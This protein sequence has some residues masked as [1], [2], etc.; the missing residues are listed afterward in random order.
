MFCRSHPLMSHNWMALQQHPLHRRKRTQQPMQQI[1]YGKFKDDFFILWSLFINYFHVHLHLGI[2]HYFICSPIEF[3]GHF[4]LQ[5]VLL[6]RGNVANMIRIETKI[7]ETKDANE[8]RQCAMFD[9]WYSYIVPSAEEK[10][11]IKKKFTVSEADSV[12]CVFFS[13]SSGELIN[14]IYY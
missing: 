10:E 14:R 6:V 3:L 7:K 12:F 4:Y 5:W 8:M 11:K 9:I 1:I 2:R 13:F